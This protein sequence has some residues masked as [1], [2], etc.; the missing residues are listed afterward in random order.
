MQYF[1]KRHTATPTITT[2]NVSLI[3]ENYYFITFVTRKECRYC[4][5]P[6]KK[7]LKKWKFL[8]CYFGICFR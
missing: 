7:Q 4:F 2:K 8:K 1:K 3:K 6:S 5:K